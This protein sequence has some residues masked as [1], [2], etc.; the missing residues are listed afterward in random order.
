MHP[1]IIFY[2][3]KD[4]HIM[5]SLGEILSETKYNTRIEVF[6]GTDPWF[7]LSSR[8]TIIK[9]IELT[10]R[11]NLIEYDGEN[12]IAMIEVP[13]HSDTVTTRE[14]LEGC[15]K[16][17]KDE[18][19]NNKDFSYKDMWIYMAHIIQV[20]QKAGKKEINIDKK[21]ISP[22]EFIKKF[23]TQNDIRETFLSGYCYYFAN[24]LKEAFNRGTIVWAAPYSH[25]CWMDINDNVYDADGLRNDHE[26]ELY[27]PASYFSE[28][29]LADFKHVNAYH[30]GKEE[31]SDPKDIMYCYAKELCS[32][33]G[34]VFI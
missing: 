11:A 12:N 32:S 25:I 34:Y 2:Y 17:L 19:D 28:K 29:D 20:T 5:K 18:K 7:G 3:R 31:I 15:F 6:L 10:L 23:V 24:I 30:I 16:L 26:V 9:S 27:V 21:L 33:A 22:D 4:N 1:P 13:F 8:Y 14:S